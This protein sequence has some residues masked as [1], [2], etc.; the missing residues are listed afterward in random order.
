MS[1]H[2]ID[3]TK[4]NVDLNC[5]GLLPGLWQIYAQPCPPNPP[6]FNHDT[7]NNIGQTM[8]CLSTAVPQ[9]WWT[10]L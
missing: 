8:F 1:W 4:K 3:A 7:Y 6:H 10:A 9:L 2:I 5:N